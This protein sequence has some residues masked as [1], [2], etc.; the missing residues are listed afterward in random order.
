M[1]LGKRLVH[2]E[3][4]MQG[5]LSAFM[6]QL[7]QYLPNVLG[8]L[9]ILVLGWLLA[10]GIKKFVAAVLS[11][12]RLDERLA[13]KSHE[14]LQL[15][16]LLTGLVYYLVLL[17][18]L[19][20]TLEALG[21]VGVLAPVMNMVDSFLAILPNLVAAALIGVV[22]Y[23]LAKILANA[24]LIGGQG[25][26]GM[27]QKAGLSDKIKLPRLV[28][29]VVF[30][31]IFIPVLISALGVLNIDAISV[32]ATQMLSDLLAAV[33]DILGAAVILA[34]A[35]V[36]GRFITNILRDLLQNMGTDYW[37]ERLGVGR[38]L[39]PETQFSQFVANVAFFFIMLAASV[40]AAEKLTILLLADALNTLLIFAAQI[41]LGLVI[42]IIGNYIATFAYKALANSP[43]KSALATVARVAI[44]SLVLA[45]GLKAMGIADD[46]V[47]LAFGLA[48]GGV[49]VAFALS[50]G[51]GGREAAGRQMEHWLSRL[52]EKG[53]S[54]EG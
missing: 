29:Q 7:G 6:N 47:N 13:E 20:L 39:G 11:R 49:A 18:V 32:P 36:L 22:G 38:L 44:L 34:V 35:Y 52:R 30:L 2:K 54:K 46:I 48:L 45:M 17:F 5:F 14:P 24:V 26:N 42:L 27:A 21:V 8:A 53:G 40:S 15:E 10:I 51:L 33:P 43:T 31:V 19:L 12:L 4:A 3:D 41:V 28:S 9:V 25:L 23:V 50:F 16:K 37:P 1:E